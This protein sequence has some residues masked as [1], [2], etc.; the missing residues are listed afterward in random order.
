M[1]SMFDR[2]KQDDRDFERNLIESARQDPLP[3]DVQGAW[4]KFTGAMGLVTL[5]VES[6]SHLPTVQSP[7]GAG[8]S[9]LVL[10]GMVRRA[11]RG[12][13][14][15][16]L[17]VGA[18]GGSATTAL[19][20]YKQSGTEH[21]P[22][23]PTTETAAPMPVAAV[24]QTVQ[25]PAHEA[26]P[27]PVLVKPAPVVAKPLHHGRHGW[28]GR[29]GSIEQHEA[30]PAATIATNVVP[31]PLA[32]EVAMLDAA[33]NA[34]RAGAYAEAV[35]IV[36][37]YHRDFPGGALAPDA[38]VVAIEALAEMDK[39]NEVARRATRFLSQYP[40]DPHS[41]RVKRLSAER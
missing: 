2:S 39:R 36:D 6:G 20:A 31:S 4:A 19:I 38:E 8:A 12:R 27:P 25:N 13:A 41:N 23:T 9:R 34:S 24:L 1:T 22:R 40:A 15:K 18:M 16:W 3:G 30:A 37:R 32:A 14:M 26:S 17:L 21:R 11:V 28:H 10:D 33:R 35:R 7:S 5:G 29:Q